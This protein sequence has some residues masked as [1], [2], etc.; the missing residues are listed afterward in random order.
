MLL[1][2]VINRL[3]DRVTALRSIAGAADLRTAQ[4]ELKR[5]PAAWVF[6]AAE[7]A[8]ANETVQVVSQRVAATFGV[9]LAVQNVS[10]AHGAAARDDL[11]AVRANVRTAL[12]AWPPDAD[13]EPC[14]FRTGRLLAFG[15]QVL[16]WV[17]EYET[18]YY[19]RA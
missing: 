17:D 15:D 4:S 7:R 14:V 13:H 18:S 11:E 19:V 9:L 16:W 10:D 1:A 8:G 6:L 12:L 3:R 2:L 5:A